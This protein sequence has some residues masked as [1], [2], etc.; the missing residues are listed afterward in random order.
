LQFLLFGLLHGAYLSV[1]H[2]WRIFGPRQPA[3][4]VS[5][6]ASA[7]IA[8]GQV[9]LTYL[10]VLV[11]QI[12]FRASSAQAALKILAELAGLHGANLQGAD[13]PAVSFHG[14][15][16][17]PLHAVTVV[18]LFVVCWAFPNTQ[19]IM[20]QFEPSI[21]KFEP[22]SARIWRWQPTLAWAGV[23][24]LLFIATLGGRLG[25]PARFLYFQF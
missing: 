16:A 3:V 13:L 15:H 24:A 14:N 7:A 23:I 9:L 10:A 19:Q 18:L 4:R 8:A 11:G 5:R 20:A 6:V 12:F 22:G 21:S 17:Q 1:N 2:A 25:D